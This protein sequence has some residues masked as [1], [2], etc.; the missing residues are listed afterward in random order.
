[1]QRSLFRRG[2]RR[3]LRPSSFLSALDD[4]AIDVL[5][6]RV[7]APS[8]SISI[9]FLEPLHG[10]ASASGP[11]D[12]AFSH[13]GPGHSFAALSIWVDPADREA[14]TTWVR[15]FFAEMGPYLAT[16]VYSNYLGGDEGETRVR[17]AYGPA[18]DRLVELK[19]A[20]DP[21]NVFRL[22]QNVRPG[23]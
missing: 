17:A 12:S 10:R 16:G 20:Y 22:N 7:A 14:C 6:A 21:D 9:F 2:A 23:A 3:E 5:A 4:E 13:R 19:R 1:M 8:P 18:W 15:D 11:G